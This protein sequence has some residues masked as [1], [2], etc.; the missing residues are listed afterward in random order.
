V[1]RPGVR[2]TITLHNELE[3]IALLTEAA[4]AGIQTKRARLVAVGAAGVERTLRGA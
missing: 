3:D 2:Y 1:N 4:M